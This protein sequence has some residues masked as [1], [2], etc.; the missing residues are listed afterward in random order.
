[1]KSSI[2]ARRFLTT[3]TLCATFL[4]GYLNAYSYVFNQN[5]YVTPQTGNLISLAVALVR[6]DT[7]STIINFMLLTGFALGCI[8]GGVLLLKVTVNHRCLVWTWSVFT[9]LL[10]IVYLL[11]DG[12]SQPVS[13]ILLSLLS[14]FALTLFRKVGKIDVNNGIMT[15]NFKNLYLNLVQGIAKNNQQQVT[16]SLIFLL[17][18]M[19]FFLGCLLGGYLSNFCEQITLIVSFLICL[20]PYLSLI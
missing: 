15:G 19:I 2:K 20:V 10:I 16:K 5:S 11:N 8:I 12:L 14:G 17:V 9:L 4:L 6:D 3:V 7:Q 13:V 1:M 18:I